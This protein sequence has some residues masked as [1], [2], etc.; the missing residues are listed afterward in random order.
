MRRDIKLE[1]L[2]LDASKRLLKLADFGY[3]KRDQ[4]SLCRSHVGTPDYA[5]AQVWMRSCILIT[6]HMCSNSHNGFVQLLI[7]RMPAAT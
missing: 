5:G 6:M 7:A 2:L 3:A 4:D 1:N